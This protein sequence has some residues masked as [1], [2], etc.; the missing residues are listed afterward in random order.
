MGDDHV[1]RPQVQVQ[2][3]T[4]P[5]GTNC[6]YGLRKLR[7]PLRGAR[8]SFAIAFTRRLSFKIHEHFLQLS[9]YYVIIRYS[10]LRWPWR[11]GPPL[12]IP[13]REV[14]PASA[15]GTATPG[16]RVGRRLPSRA[17]SLYVNGPFFYGVYSAP[18]NFSYCFF[19]KFLRETI[20]IIQFY[21]SFIR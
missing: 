14:K 18:N 20:G 12:S 5:S 16:G 21:L 9:H 11:R 7:C 10:R 15:D 17:H 19:V 1:D 2:Q 8:E 6:P 3:C 4:Q 13:N